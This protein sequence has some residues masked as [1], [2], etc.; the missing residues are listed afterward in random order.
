MS[1]RALE[2]TG[3]PAA[4]LRHLA[5]VPARGCR[6]HACAAPPTP[7][8]ATLRAVHYVWTLCGRTHLCSAYSNKQRTRCYE[9]PLASRARHH[10]ERSLIGQ[11]A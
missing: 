8:A 11:E 3:R 5:R 9:R 2:S 1:V 6:A 10:N 4:P 7:V